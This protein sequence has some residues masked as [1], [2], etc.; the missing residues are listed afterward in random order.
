[1][2]ALTKKENLAAHPRENGNIFS[3]LTF[4]WVN[5][6]LNASQGHVAITKLIRLGSANSVKRP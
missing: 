1:M 2:E 5:T 6:Y 4:A 3:Y